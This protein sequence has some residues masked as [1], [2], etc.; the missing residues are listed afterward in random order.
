MGKNTPKNKNAWG[1][2]EGALIFAA[3]SMLADCSDSHPRSRFDV[4][5]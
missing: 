4:G 5:W 3:N 1:L 2:D